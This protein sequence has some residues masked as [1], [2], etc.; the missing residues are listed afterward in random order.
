MTTLTVLTDASR[1]SIG[2]DIDFGGVPMRV[3]RIEGNTVTVQHRH[4][5]RRLL[6]WLRIKYRTLEAWV[7]EKLD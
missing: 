1:M 2:D 7:M 6:S 5:Y 3:I 4:W